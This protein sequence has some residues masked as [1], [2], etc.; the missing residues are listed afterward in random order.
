MYTSRKKST[1]KCISWLHNEIDSC[2]S[3]SISKFIAFYQLSRGTTYLHWLTSGSNLNLIYMKKGNI[4]LYQGWI[5]L[6]FKVVLY[7]LGIDD[8]FANMTQPWILSPETYTH[9]N[10][11]IYCRRIPLISSGSSINLQKLVCPRK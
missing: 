4:L 1:Y 3:D 11:H 6:I 2:F 9:K 5:A 7:H 8:I 10:V